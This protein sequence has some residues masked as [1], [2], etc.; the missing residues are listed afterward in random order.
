MSFQVTKQMAQELGIQLYDSG[1]NYTS[2]FNAAKT[3]SI[4]TFPN[5]YCYKCVLFKCGLEE[6]LL[7][8]L[9]AETK[10]SIL[11]LF[12]GMQNLQYQRRPEF[13]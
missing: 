7:C 13:T 1:Y 2:T 12:W 8:T 9:C 6:T 11:D 3:P 4:K 5:N 10:E